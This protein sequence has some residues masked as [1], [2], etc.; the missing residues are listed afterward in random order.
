[1][2]RGAGERRS[3]ETRSRRQGSE[4]RRFGLEPPPAA[5]TQALQ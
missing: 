3:G 2:G 4:G 1:M 5:R